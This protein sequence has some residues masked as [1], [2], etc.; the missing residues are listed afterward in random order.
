LRILAADYAREVRQGTAGVAVMTER[1]IFVAAYQEPNPTA[2]RALLD[3]ACESD[4]ALRARVEALLKKAA[5]AGRFLE[6]SPDHRP[7]PD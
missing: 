2:R 4:P 5:E 1:E 6:D 7:S 3:R